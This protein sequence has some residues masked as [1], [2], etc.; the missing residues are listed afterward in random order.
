ML[1]LVLGRSG[2]GKTEYIRNIL[3]ERAKASDNK[4]LLI[5]PEQFSFASERSFLL[6]ISAKDAQNIEVLSFSRLCDYVGRSLGG[7]AGTHTGDDTKIIIML[8][9]LNSIQDSLTLYKKHVKSIPLAK[10]LIVLVSELKKECISPEMLKTA[11]KNVRQ[12]T[13]KNK[14]SDLSII[15][16]AYETLFSSKYV[17]YID[18]D[19]L[20]ERLAKTLENNLFFNGYTICIDAFKGFTGQEFE[21]IKHLISQADEV[22]VSLCTPNIYDD[23]PAMIFASVNETAKKLKSLSNKTKIIDTLNKPLRFNNDELKFLEANIFNPTTKT[24]KSANDEKLDTKLKHIEI[25][26]ADNIH[27]ECMYIAATARK[28]IREEGITLKDIAIIVRNDTN[29][30]YE[31]TNCFKR[32]DIPVFEDKRAPVKTQ[33]II[34]LMISVLNILNGGFTT[35]NILRYLKTDLSPLSAE[36]VA[37]LENY[38]LMWNLSAKAW[39]NKFTNN[40]NGL[41]GESD[42]EKLKKLNKMREKIIPPLLTLAEKTKNTT[43]FEFSEALYDFLV[44]TDIDTRLLTLAEELDAAGYTALAAEQNRVW[45]ILM[46]ILSKLGL[47]YGETK[48]DIETY[49]NLFTAVV[50]VTDL[51]SIPFVLDEITIGTADRIRLSNPKVV[52]VAG[53]AEGV[54]PAAISNNSLL[55][56]TDRA[57]LEKEGIVLSSSSE[58]LASEE[59]FIAYSALTSAT[60]KVFISYYKTDDEASYKPSIIINSAKEL[61]SIEDEKNVSAI[62]PEYFAETY[63]SVFQTYAENFHKL[64]TADDKF[65]TKLNSLREITKEDGRIKTLD[66]VANKLPFKIENKNTAK[67]LFGENLYLS[68]SRVD[69]YYHCPFQYFCKYGLKAKPRKKAKLD[70]LIGGTVIHYVLENV[71]REYGK[72]KLIA[73]NK[74][75]REKAVDK[76]L[77][78]YLDEK[79]GGF[80][81]KTLRF[82]YLYRRLS[83][84]LVDIVNRLCDEFSV[85]NFTPCDFE[86]SIGTKDDSKLNSSNSE[87]EIEVKETLEEK[88]EK[89]PIPAYTVNFD[90]NKEIKIFGEIDR[91]DKF[92]KNGQSYIRVVDYKSGGKEFRLSDIL[93]GL[94]MQMLIYLFA[95]EAGGKKRYG[96]TIPSGILYYTAKRSH[97][98]LDSKTEDPLEKKIY[99]DKGSGLFLLNEDVLEAMEANIKG[100]YIPVKYNRSG[101]LTGNLISLE[102][103]IKLKKNIDNTLIAMATNLHNGEIPAFPVTGTNYDRTCEYCDYRAICGVEDDSIKKEIEKKDNE[104]VLEIINQQ[105]LE[106][107]ENNG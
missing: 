45:E 13:L 70:P 34:S 16:D 28:L 17:D 103:M 18:G 71:V 60:D 88:S 107:G 51:G 22:Y 42:E 46:E 1:N 105:F 57:S 35:E 83:V 29:Y 58:N 89:K 106:A 7:F 76:W 73:L 69:T 84:S 43:A 98:S 101:Q 65:V 100:N 81:D 63:D 36:D 26:S 55:T 56:T 48:T 40:P 37:E 11:S 95:I 14:L 24:F 8:R 50:E 49:K 92:E 80:E 47:I 77:K 15:Y 87:L 39:R 97:V 5:V 104:T 10:E 20:L 41:D 31:L 6:D 19:S 102:D 72:E 27:D 96:E 99:A 4:L 86:L 93:D 59:R 79:L 82:R 68:A 78:I 12:A 62:E 30:S 94:N 53:C 54:F 33:P 74:N 66:M 90:N 85:S 32:F 2:S 91:V 23:D 9:A 67:A 52:F 38:V 61:F 25:F 75:E 21:I 44:N 3:K 64:K